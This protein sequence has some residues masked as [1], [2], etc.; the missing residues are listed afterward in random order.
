VKPGALF[1]QR[2]GSLIAAGF[3]STAS[4]AAFCALGCVS[5]AAN[6]SALATT[7]GI[8]RTGKFQQLERVV[9][10]EHGTNYR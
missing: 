9:V 5:V 4:V 3:V 7:Y 6:V 8:S 1:S 10:M 2:T